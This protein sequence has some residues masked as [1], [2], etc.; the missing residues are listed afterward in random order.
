MIPKKKIRNWL[1]GFS[2]IV[3]L[4][5]SFTLQ[6][7]N[8]GVVT[9]KIVDVTGEPLI[10]VN[11][12]IKGTTKGTITD[13]KGEFSLQ[14]NS[15]SI[16]Q[17]SY[18]GYVTQQIIG[19][20][21]NDTKIVMISDSKLI[22]EVVVIGYGTVKKSDLTG[23]V[24]SV[25]MGKLS[26]KN[27]SGF[28]Q[29]LQGSIAGVQTRE[30]S[31]APGAALS[32]QVRGT[33]SI[34]GNVQPLYVIDGVPMVTN[35]NSSLISTYTGGNSNNPLS[36]LNTNDIESMEVLK[37]ASATAIYGS[38]GANGVVMITTKSG[39]LGKTKISVNI[40]HSIAQD[41]TYF[42]LLKSQDY[43]NMVNESAATTRLDYPTNA[44]LNPVA[45]DATEMSNLAYYDHQKEIKQQGMVNDVNISIQGG[46]SK[47]KYFISGQYFNQDGTAPN[48]NM[49]RYNG[50]INYSREVLKNLT[51]DL[52]INTTRT[53]QN[54]VA[55][56]IFLGS[57]MGTAIS[58]APTSPFYNPNG[59]YNSISGWWYG[60]DNPLVIPNV[61]YGDLLVKSR[62]TAQQYNNLIN[63][64]LPSGIQNAMAVLNDMVNQTISN[65]LIT[66]FGANY[67]INNHWALKGLV[68]ATTYNVITKS[69]RPN[70]IP[71]QQQI[72]GFAYVGNSQSVNMLYEATAS[73][74]YDFGK[75]HMNGVLG[76]TAETFTQDT[77]VASAAGFTQ[78]ITGA[79]NIGSGAT[80]QN[81]TSNI[82]ENQLLSYLTRSNYNYDNKYYITASA[83][84]DGSSRFTEGKRFGFFPSAAI[85]WRVN[86]E[87][88]LKDNKIISNLK[89]RFSAGQ[90]GNQAISDYQTL[91]LLTTGNNGGLNYNPSFG[92]TANIGYSFSSLTN[93]SLKWE[94]NTQYNAGFDLGLFDERISLSSDVYKRFS[95]NLLFSVPVPT[96]TGFSTMT[97]NVASTENIGIEATLGA[98]IIDTKD[99]N[100]NFD[101]NIGLNHNTVN[102]ISGNL[103]S[104]N[105]EN[106]G[107]LTKL[108]VGKPIGSLYTY[109]A[110]P[111][112]TEESL[113]TKPATLQP[114][115]KIGDLR[116]KDVDSDN[117]ITTNDRELQG[118]VQP[119]FQ[120]GFSTSVSYKSFQ[121]SASFTYSYGGKGYNTF[122]RGIT[123]PN[124]GNVLQ[125]TYDNRYVRA[126]VGMVGWTDEQKAAQKLINDNTYI[127]AIGAKINETTYA[128]NRF[129]SSTSFIRC[130][131]MTLSYSLPSKWLKIAHIEA[132]RIYATGGN[133]FLLTNYSGYN[134]E[135]PITSLSNMGID[136]GSYPRARTFK[137]GMTIDL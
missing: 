56:S 27:I 11:V 94:I 25:K 70:F 73:Y 23:A 13:V 126:D 26:E 117:V 137:L 82:T 133:L 18:I 15:N 62:L 57:P 51:L 71:I 114:G 124:T 55:S 52:N 87:D 101:F 127:T 100:W 37:D 38:R 107:L 20:S 30:T 28:Q 8:Q 92:S 110:L 16:I 93:K 45:F 22:D 77:Q 66:N 4:L 115:A 104:K 1:L 6:G 3:G 116:V 81:P 10:G 59:S 112:W 125:S 42:N 12:S 84:I 31:G 54:G 58:W 47:G 74:N 50:K 106:G 41:P 29:I 63:S 44:A 14:A 67:K 79:N 111:V 36:F 121:L 78:D 113:L 43:A 72:S 61:N 135:T 34:T 128:T 39:K 19:S 102:K 96:T 60:A 123:I 97:A 17:I 129:I 109:T 46:D 7:Q 49:I 103:T 2:V 89:V 99:F 48:S 64:L 91:S 132:V 76:A 108:E 35:D 122:I 131:N 98:V 80:P 118:Y 120:G 69:Y 5:S 65:N 33:G 9:G 32:I 53:S 90:T 95:N 24:G 134:P 68:S 21:I 86:N 88:F 40:A 83:R 75:S 85:S 105:Y 119:K 130:T 136:S